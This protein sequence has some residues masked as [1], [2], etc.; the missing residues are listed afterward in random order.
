MVFG[1]FSVVALTVVI[2]IAVRW[3]ARGDMQRV[4]L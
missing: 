3:E 1:V 4:V 2:M